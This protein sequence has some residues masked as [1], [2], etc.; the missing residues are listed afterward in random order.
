MKLLGIGK[1]CSSIMVINTD[2]QLARMDKYINT[3]TNEYDLVLKVTDEF[4]LVEVIKSKLS[5]EEIEL[6]L[7]LYKKNKN[8]KN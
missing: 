4:E 3:L 5:E 8:F 6:K 7:T 1:F 2:N